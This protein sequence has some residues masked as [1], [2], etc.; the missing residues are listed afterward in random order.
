MA[1][2][3]TALTTT[4]LRRATQ[5]FVSEGGKSTTYYI[6]HDAVSKKAHQSL[7]ICTA[8]KDAPIKVVVTG[9]MEEK[10]GKKIITASKIEEDK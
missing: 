4:A 8:K 3:R 9:T 5:R 1:P 7:G 10:D 6:K 2:L